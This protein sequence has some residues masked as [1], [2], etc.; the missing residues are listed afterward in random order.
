MMFLG[1]WDAGETAFTNDGRSCTSRVPTPVA[2]PLAKNTKHFL[3]LRSL[4]LV[5]ASLA[6]GPCAFS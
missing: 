6:L 1:I 3:C 2:I 4:S 5:C